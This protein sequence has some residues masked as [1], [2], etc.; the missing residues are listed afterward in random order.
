MVRAS[1]RTAAFANQFD[2]VNLYILR[3][4]NEQFEST[5]FLNGLSPLFHIIKDNGANWF[6]AELYEFLIG[7]QP[8]ARW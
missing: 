3:S 5:V 2:A 6:F 8:A 1:F 7:E 4:F